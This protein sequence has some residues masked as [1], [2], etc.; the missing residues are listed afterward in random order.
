[1]TRGRLGSGT[2]QAGDRIRGSAG[3]ADRAKTDE[4]DPSGY[5]GHRRSGPKICI[6]RQK[7][8]VAARFLAAMPHR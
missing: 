7:S 3:T 1:V 5:A 6:Q 8:A 4:R 2:R